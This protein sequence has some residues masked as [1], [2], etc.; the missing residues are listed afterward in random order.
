MISA[1]IKKF[2]EN[3][4][5]KYESV[6]HKIVYTA[7]DKAATLRVKEEAVAKTLVV[8]LDPP[9]PGLRQGKTHA[10][11]LLTACERYD[12]FSRSKL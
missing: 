4:K 6:G 10:V 8:K 9:S 12:V 5:V 3:K 1:K 11:H 2:L 7:Y